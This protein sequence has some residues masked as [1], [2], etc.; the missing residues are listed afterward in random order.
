MIRQLVAALVEAGVEA[1]AEAIA[2]SLWLARA[3]RDETPSGDQ[4]LASTVRTAPT[5]PRP[6]DAEPQHPVDNAQ[7]ASLR[8][9]SWRPDGPAAPGPASSGP[10]AAA[11]SIT[12]RKARALPG[13]LELGRALRPLKQRHPSK[14]DYAM[15]AEATVE[16]FCDTG[17]LTPVMRPGAERWFDVNVLID[18][19]PSMAVWQDT[20]VELVSLLE[21]HGAF[22]EVRHWTLEQVEGKVR[23]SRPAS[24]RSEAPQLVDPDARRLTM[25]VTDCIG[26]MW[27]QAPIWHAIRGWGLSSPVVIT[28]MLPP[29]LWP[30]TALGSPEVTMWSHRPGTANRSLDV[31]LPWWWPDDDPPPS[32]VPVPVITLEA[33]SVATWAHMLMGAGGVETRGVF[34]TP[35][36]R[37]GA[38]RSEDGPPDAE[39][40]VQR[41]RVTVS[42]VAYRLAVYLSAALRGPWGLALARVLQEAMLPDSSQVHLAEVV[43]GGLVRQAD[44]HTEH[45]E[46]M[47]EFVDG[48]ADV[49]QRSL[50]GTEALQVLQVLG[51]HIERQTGRSPGIAAL[52]LGETAPGDVAEQF[53]DVQAGAVNLIHAMG[54]AQVEVTPSQAT[55]APSTGVVARHDS[56]V[57]AV[58]AA[59]LGGRPVVVSGGDDATIRVS[60]LASGAAVGD[61]FTGH[62]GP[63]N[64]VAAAELGG[65]PV[66]VSGGDDATIRV[67]DLASGAAV[68]DPFT[69]HSG[70]VNAVAAAELGGRPV[71]ISASSAATVV[72]DLATGA[73][74]GDPFSIQIQPVMAVAA[75][76]L[77]GRP[78]VISGSSDG[79]VRVWDLAS[80]TP[81]DGDAF[82]IHKGGVHAVAAAELGGRPVVVSGGDDATIRVSDLASGAAVGDPFTGHSGPVNA[83]AVSEL[84]GGPVVVSGGDDATIRVWDLASG[85]PVGDPFTGHSGPVNA[86]AAAELGGR[87]VVIS[88]SSDGTVLVWNPL[89]AVPPVREAPSSAP[90]Q[91]PQTRPRGPVG[92]PPVWNLP[93]AANPAFTGRAAILDALQAGLSREL[94]MVRPQVITGTG[95]VGKTA[96]AVEY[97]WAHRADYDA[98]WWVHAETAASMHGDYADLAPQLGLGQDPDQDAMV[99]VVRDWLEDN[100]RWLL[101]FDNADD[102]AAIIPLLPQAGD[103]H[104]IVTSQQEDDLG[105]RADLV[106]LDVLTEQEATQFLLTRTGQ[107][108]LAAAGELAD[109]LGCLPLAL[110]QAGAFIAQTAVITLARY[111]ELFRQNS[112]KLLSRG[113]QQGSYQHTVDT[114]W[115]L[116]LQRLRQE[117]PAATELL[118]LLAFL[119]PDDLPWQLLAS[120]AD[121]LPE[122]LAGAAVDEVALAEVI[123]ALRR[124]SLVTVSGDALS[125]Q[126]LL[127]AVLREDLDEAA[128]QQWAAAAIG[129]LGASF[130][131]ESYDVRT[132]P[133]CQRLLSHVL[134]ATGHAERLGVQAALEGTSWLLDRAAGY[135]QGRA[136][137]TQ[138]KVLYERAL[139]IDEATLGPDH[140]NVGRDRSNLGSVLQDLGDLSGAKTQLEQALAIDEATLG[141][142]HPNV[143][144]DRS[145]LGSVLQDLGDL[146]GAKTQYERALAIDEATLGPDHPNV[147][148]DRSNLGSVLQD[149]G[150]LSGAKTQ[151]EQALAIDEAT[152]G[153]DH[154]NVGR[155]RSNLGSVLQDL[156]DLDGAKT[157][158]E[159]ALAIDEATL[160]PDHPN[161]GRDRSNLG[162][163]LQDLGDL[164]GA[165]TQ[166]ERAL[167]IDEATLGPDHPNVGRDRSNLGSMLQD[168]G[169]LDGA[170]T[171]YERALSIMQAAYG[172]DHPNVAN[173][174]NYLAQLRQRRAGPSS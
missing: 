32:G 136:Q 94:G 142:D 168:L 135:L 82:G 131:D 53:E 172:P 38:A 43:V 105:G 150:D 28:T 36:A 100:P 164:D 119:A 47:Y 110:E 25:V 88:G 54:L 174:M 12:L 71:V 122:T 65:R 149:L 124:Y 6:P 87:P 103:G 128:R 158:Y 83:V 121:Q 7:A 14:R 155:D 98:V 102:P 147:G 129:L 41:F 78:V 151:L 126:R 154:P 89:M 115:E 16:Y 5:E 9:P 127:Q 63:V 166:Y 50:T 134:A 141:P 171:Q 29:R 93:Y 101:I 3:R 56:R 140:P 108:D 79:T 160:G 123:D 169:D 17:V 118:S 40:R 61:P 84:G 86:V 139:A 52:L 117:T 45:E 162:S 62:S 39:E 157:Q 75:A 64:A 148:R 96:L 58:A 95:G 33:A 1:D 113:R 2:D 173:V 163:V 112:L 23:L 35:P 42:P 24:V 170:K 4:Q 81:I 59:E 144:R 11:S 72:T 145:N 48:V 132:W 13:A 30:R 69:G 80:G 15:D 114:T 111:L 120:H 46:P 44:R 167:A 31:A 125:T 90:V 137:F 92:L 143:G 37:P 26:P 146:S 85:A 73:P 97:A 161:V 67:S 18:A 107:T 104:V 74:V 133:D 51:G 8:A 27:Y 20:G 109:A 152:L 138:A 55:E 116:S 22:R 159:R 91:P 68:G 99:A 49:L 10:G 130:P 70:P 19:S 76:E 60:D 21:R 153:P 156:G 66:V 165:K 77:G 106:P 34:A 57:G